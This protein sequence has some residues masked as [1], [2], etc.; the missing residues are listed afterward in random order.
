MV[1]DYHWIIIVSVSTEMTEMYITGICATFFIE[2]YET[3][4]NTLSLALYSLAKN[5]HIQDE[6]ARHIQESIHANNNEITYD[7]I[8]K[9]EYLEK[10]AFGKNFDSCVTMTMR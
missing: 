7:L 8:Y 6:L 1:K 9:N 10:V 4:A 5:P 3:S 2:A